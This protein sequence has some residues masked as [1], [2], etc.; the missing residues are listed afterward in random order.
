[1]R[2]VPYYAVYGIVR[3]EV[4]NPILSCMLR[5]VFF[6]NNTLLLVPKPYSSMRP[7]SA[8]KHH[9]FNCKQIFGEQFQINFCGIGI[10]VQTRND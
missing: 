10:S 2:Y 4:K 5:A 8:A 3:L 9:Y 7:M 1:M 6:A